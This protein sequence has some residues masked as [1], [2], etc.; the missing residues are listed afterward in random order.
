[1]HKRLELPILISYAVIFIGMF[2]WVAF[3]RLTYPLDLEWMEGGMLMHA[4]RI[5]EGKGIYLPP[6][7][8][9]VPYFYTPGYPVVLAILGTIFEI[10]YPLARSLS[11]LAWLGTSWLMY[12]AVKRESSWKYGVLSVGIY[13]ALFRTNGAFYDIARPDSLFLFFVFGALYVT[14]F[15]K[16]VRGALFAGVLC[17]LGFLTK[18]TASV[19]FVAICVVQVT[20]SWREALAC[21]G[22]GAVVAVSGCLLL[23]LWSDGWFWTYIFEGHQGHVFI[24]NNILLE[25]W[26]DLLFLAPALLLLPLIHFTRQIK[27]KWLSW[28]L[29]VHWAY[30]FWV[31]TQSLDYSPHMY[32]RE[33]WYESPRY[34]ILLPPL[35]L[36]LSVAVILFRLKSQQVSTSW[37]WLWFFIAGC[38][39]S[40]LNHS[41]Q[42][43]YANCFMPI[44]IVG[45]VLIALTIRDI[46]ESADGWSNL[47]L[48]IAMTTQCA[49]LFYL[50]SKQL[51]TKSDRLVYEELSSVLEG[52]EGAILFA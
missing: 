52:R 34:L 21:A 32:Y 42:W 5:A 11:L 47:A 16:S 37:V 29:V 51:P 6:S 31:R 40:A 2:L 48:M 4:V 14:R 8:E 17:A 41:T 27:F 49:A 38:G 50:P 13:A 45:S 44:S 39:V 30:A 20:R 33:L 26:R 19:F 9:F 12:S 43:A 22:A 25:Y 46:L 18:Q 10:G 7:T 36:G 24:W 1:M 3:H 15:S 35:I 28:I 23:N